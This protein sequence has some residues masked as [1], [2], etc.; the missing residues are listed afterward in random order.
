LEDK[1]IDAFCIFKANM[2]E[3]T[4]KYSHFK[5]YHLNFLPKSQK[6]ASGIL[7]G[8]YKPLKH[9]FSIVKK[10]NSVDKTKI[11]KLNVWKNENIKVFGIYNPPQ[12]NP[13][14]SLLD[15]TKRTLV[16]GNFNAH[17]HDVGYKNINEAGKTMDNFISANTVELLYEKE[18]PTTYL[19]YSGSTTSPDLTLASDIAALASRNI[20]HDPGCGHR[21]IITTVNFKTTPGTFNNNLHYVWNFKKS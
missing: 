16:V 2:I 6:I 1:E 7:T 14:L 18:D 11:I 8:I 10:M 4:I 13:T 12:N 15:V 17:F 21:M 3:K 20:I 9:I 5:N 19:H